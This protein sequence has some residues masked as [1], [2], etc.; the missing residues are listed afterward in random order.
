MDDYSEDLEKKLQETWNEIAKG[1]KDCV[2]VH[3]KYRPNFHKNKLGRVAHEDGEYSIYRFGMRIFNRMNVPGRNDSRLWGLLPGNWAKMSWY[4]ITEKAS[5][6]LGGIHRLYMHELFWHGP[7]GL[8]NWGEGST[9]FGS[10]IQDSTEPLE[11]TSEERQ[12]LRD[13]FDME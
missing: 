2:K 6:P 3:V 7:G 10:T 12:G 11:F 8:H 1:T 4:H 9:N 5:N 13:A